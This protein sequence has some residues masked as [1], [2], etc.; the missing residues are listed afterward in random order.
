MEEKKIKVHPRRLARQMVKNQ[1][2]RANVTGVNKPTPGIYGKNG[3]SRFAQQ[4]R[5][6]AAEIVNPQKT[7]RMRKKG[8]KK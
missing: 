3:Q 5:K 4:W 1:L 2:D 7:R 8:A 6:I